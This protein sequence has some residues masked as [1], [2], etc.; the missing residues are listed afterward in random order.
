MKAL[1]YV[2][3]KKCEVQDRPAP[4]VE[5]PTDAVLKMLYTSICGTDLHI[6]KGDVPVVEPGRILGHEGIGMIES[7]GSAVRGLAIG[8]IVLISCI[9]SCGVCPSCRKGLNSHCRSGGWMLGSVLDGT[10]AEYVRIPHA[11]SSLY[12]LPQDADMQACVS[13]SD[14][15]PTGLECG[16]TNASV[17]P[18]SRVAIVGA[19]PVGLAALLTAKLYTPSL[20]VMFDVDESRLAHAK[21]LGADKVFNPDKKDSMLKLESL[22]GDEGFDSVIEAVGTPRTFE[23]CQTL[24]AP[25][26]AI[27]NIGV[28]GQKVDLA[29]D[30]LWEHNITIK[31]RLVD[32][33]T[34]PMLLQLY[35]ARK[36]DPSKLLTHHYR[37]SEIGEAYK[38]FQNP[39]GQGLLKVGIQF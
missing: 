19:G 7:L 3:S 6:L 33:V 26:G 13:F 16:T 39:S 31:T 32:T 2:G 36:L 30:R 24:V 22:V 17:Q 34:I 9:S 20:L 15:L 14:A 38:S 1:V 5:S 10:Q 25:G 4:I 11:A 18:G 29:L 27:A 35:G 8:D 12:K 37:F 28:H 23:L 21:R